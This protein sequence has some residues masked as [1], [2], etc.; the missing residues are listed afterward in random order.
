MVQ[1][2]SPSLSVVALEPQPT[3]RLLSPANPCSF[4]RLKISPPHTH[5]KKRKLLSYLHD[6]LL[7]VLHAQIFLMPPPTSP[8]H[9]NLHGISP[10]LPDTQNSFLLLFHPVVYFFFISQPFNK[11]ASSVLSVCPGCLS[12]QPPL[13]MCVGVAPRT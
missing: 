5:G 12:S 7:A 3:S 2:G 4:S 6:F 10:A 1:R 11:C 9:P 8:Y 13:L